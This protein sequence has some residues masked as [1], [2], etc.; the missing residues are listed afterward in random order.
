LF[1]QSLLVEHS[2]AEDETNSTKA[3]AVVESQ[4]IVFEDSHSDPYD[5]ANYFGFNHAPSVTVLSGERVMSVWFSGPFEGSVDQIILASVSKDGGKTW[6]K[7][8]TIQDEPRVS[9]FDPGFINAGDQTLLFFS[10]GRWADLPSP[11]PKKGDRPHVGVDSFHVLLMSSDDQGTTWSEPRDIG[12]GLGW[13]CRS[14][15][16]K[17]KNGTLLIPTHHLKFPHISSVLLSADDGRTWKRGP[18]IETPESVGSA[19]PSVAELPDGKLI[20]VLRTTDGNLWLASSHD[21][22]QTWQQPE[23]QPVVAATSSASLLC[24]STGKLVLT[25]NPTKPPLRTEL[26]VRVSRDAAKTWS[27]PVTITKVNSDSLAAKASATWSEQVCYPSVC[28]L[29]D[30]TLLVVWARISLGDIS[31]SGVIC[32]ARVRLN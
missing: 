19:E 2:G 30:K 1:C 7:A 18:N 16:I 12:A 31:Q 11:G 22:G 9:D 29:P 5:R 24:T 32:S 26:T 14:N 15:G 3:I 28:E 8:H 21:H 10:N 23:R 13:N 25:H 4:S 20:M 6:G 27:E 17:L